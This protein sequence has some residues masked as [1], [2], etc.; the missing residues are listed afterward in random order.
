MSK[1]FGLFAGYQYYPLGGMKDFR[2]RFDTVEEAENEGKRL[3]NLT[4]ADWWQV[5]D[6]QTFETVKEWSEEWM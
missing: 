3:N 1:R 5:I 6:L 4:D 2:G